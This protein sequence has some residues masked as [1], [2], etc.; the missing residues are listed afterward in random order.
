M[1][2]S[3]I[4]YNEYSILLVDDDVN[5][6][7]TS[8]SGLSAMGFNVKC[9]SDGKQ[10]LSI[11]AQNDID[12]MV[13]DYFMPGLSGEDVVK[14]VRKTN[15]YIVILM[16]TG[17]A[18][19]KPAEQLLN[20]LKI[21]GYHDKMNGFHH[22]VVWIISC[23]RAR[24]Q[25]KKINALN[26]ELDKANSTIEKLKEN[27]VFLIERTKL[28]TKGQLISGVPFWLTS[29][30]MQV[31]S[32]LN[33]LDQAINKLFDLFKETGAEHILSESQV[34]E[35]IELISSLM[36]NIKN[37]VEDE[38]TGGIK[39]ARYL[40]EKIWY[41]DNTIKYADE[42]DQQIGDWYLYS[43]T[44][45]FVQFINNE[46]TSVYDTLLEVEEDSLGFMENLDFHGDVAVLLQVVYNIVI[47]CAK[48][49]SKY[50]V[51]KKL[52]QE[53]E[54]VQDIGKIYFYC[55]ETSDIQ[56]TNVKYIKIYIEVHNND[57]STCARESILEECSNGGI[58]LGFFS[59]QL[60]LKERFN[61]QLWSEQADGDDG[62]ISFGIRLP[63]TV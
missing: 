56:D 14:E 59:C 57:I 34:S 7:D 27:H 53:F 46:L 55:T 52:Q 13:I 5:L 48:Y 22:L 4:N 44:N 33:E 26:M 42:I 9:A 41:Y 25:Q 10:A 19:D 32:Y 24:Y 21:Q 3:T 43:I 54:M 63:F 35:K 58:G 23:I 30:I 15:P 40:K 45:R 2:S 62:K 11:L 8:F 39:S 60:L 6:L 31:S 29:S 12:V 61:G 38:P 20:S 18:G 51:N 1:E 36:C 49:M 47:T 37:L 16:Q 50:P 28:S 17:F